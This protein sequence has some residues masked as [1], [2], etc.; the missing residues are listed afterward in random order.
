MWRV[1]LLTFTLSL[2]RAKSLL[3]EDNFQ[4][5]LSLSALNGS[6]SPLLMVPA[7]GP[8]ERRSI[9]FQEDFSEIGIGN[10]D[11]T[12][13]YEEDLRQVRSL[14]ADLADSPLY[15]DT[16]TTNNIQ[17][18]HLSSG[19]F[20]PVVSQTPPPS[21]PSSPGAE[22]VVK[23][24]PEV[25]PRPRPGLWRPPALCDDKVSGASQILSSSHL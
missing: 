7:L 13:S 24:L 25:Q 6:H 2:S 11:Y 8:E 15:Y 5:S 12:G 18:P 22:V 23:G 20:V 9:T 21:P 17:Q 10:L 4:P 3:E 1:S 16:F 19:E 14:L